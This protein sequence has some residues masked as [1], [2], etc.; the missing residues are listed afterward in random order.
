MESRW[1]GRGDLLG[2]R[3]GEGLDAPYHRQ[4]EGVLQERGGVLA[5]GRVCT[6]AGGAG[7]FKGRSVLVAA[8]GQT[9]ALLPREQVE[10]PLQEGQVPEE[11]ALA[12][13]AADVNGVPEISQRRA[14]HI[15]GQDVTELLFLPSAAPALQVNGGLGGHLSDLR[16]VQIGGGEEAVFVSL[17]STRFTNL[18]SLSKGPKKGLV[19]SYEAL[20]CLDFL[21]PSNSRNPMGSGEFQG[22]RSD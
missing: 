2:C 7:E 13:A 6:D 4:G 3:Q 19:H 9:V 1:F 17:I 22:R 5:L 18:S 8:L 15:R 21:H 14:D 16:P 10:F 12:A 11:I 20:I